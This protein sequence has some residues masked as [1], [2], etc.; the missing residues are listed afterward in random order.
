[1]ISSLIGLVVSVV[2]TLV[3]YA[4]ASSGI[5]L[6]SLLAA[7]QMLVQFVFFLHLGHSSPVT[8]ETL[9]EEDSSW[10]GLFFA[11][12]IVITLT[13][14]IGSLWIMYNLNYRM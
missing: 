9:V 7:V 14:V 8:R 3:S 13:V 11:F 4:F 10:N 6:I 5:G 2:L 1:M 12:T